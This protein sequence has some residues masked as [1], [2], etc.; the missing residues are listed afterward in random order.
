MPRT[1][2]RKIVQITAATA[3]DGGEQWSVVYALCDDGTV[4]WKSSPSGRWEQ[5]RDIPQPQ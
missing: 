1:P 3:G 4:W 2:P 5:I